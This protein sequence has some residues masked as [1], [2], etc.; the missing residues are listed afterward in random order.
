MIH[1]AVAMLLLLGASAGAGAQ[2]EFEP[3]RATHLLPKD[4]RF[5]PDRARC[6][7]DNKAIEFCRNERDTNAV[8][9]CLRANQSP[10]VCETRKSESAKQRCERI[11]RI[12]QPCKGRRGTELAACVEQRRAAEKRKK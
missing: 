4:C 7:E 3:G 9:A 1:R 12:Y 5:E 6:E 10:L 11:N 8:H 2:V